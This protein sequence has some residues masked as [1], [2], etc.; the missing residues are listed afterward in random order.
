MNKQTET[1]ALSNVSLIA[2]GISE[3]R[4]GTEI[5]QGGVA[6]IAEGIEA[7]WDTPI[8]WSHG[9]D[10]KEVKGCTPL[11][12]IYFV[13]RGPD[14]KEDGKYMTAAYEGIADA[15][16]VDGGFTSADKQA[17]KRAFNIVAAKMAGVDVQFETVE[18]E[19]KG[20][21]I[22]V[23][24]ATVPASVAFDLVK[25][26]GSLTDG[27]KDMVARVKGNAEVLGMPVPEDQ[28]ALDGISA[29]RVKCVGGRHPVLGKVPSVT[30]LA[31]TLGAI[32]AD[33]GLMPPIK[34]RNGST[35]DSAQVFT[36]ALDMVIASLK[37]VVD[38]ASDQSDF[39]PCDA[40][41]A[42][43]SELELLL[44]SYFVAEAAAADLDA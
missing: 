26:D 3:V 14:G 11:S 39:A 28:A 21:P 7:C 25:P 38:P 1:A 34:P 37:L 12:R 8:A 5:V 44:A 13:P 15:F 41:D 33:K 32:A 2:L 35:Q 9:K 19:F 43:L 10:D 22:Q 27:A 16:G 30:D 23:R 20:R 17:F 4:E 31:N 42:K 24:A 29:M 6:H 36:K 18:R 40:I